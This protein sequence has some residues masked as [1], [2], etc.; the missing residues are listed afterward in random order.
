MGKSRIACSL[1]DNAPEIQRS[2]TLSPCCQVSRFSCLLS[3]CFGATFLLTDIP[4]ACSSRAPSANSPFSRVQICATPLKKTVRSKEGRRCTLPS[5]GTQRDFSSRHRHHRP[6]GRHRFASKV[7]KL[8]GSI[9]CFGIQQVAGKLARS[10]VA[11]LLGFM[12][13]TH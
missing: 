2:V 9:A 13:S 7:S 5:S 8:F 12:F 10:N 4:I 3:T 6:S 11:A 1:T